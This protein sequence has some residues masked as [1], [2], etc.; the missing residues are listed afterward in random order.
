[1]TKNEKKV[2][3]STPETIKKKFKV[4]CAKHE[5]T[6]KYVLSEVMYRAVKENKLP[7]KLSKRRV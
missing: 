7:I 6:I 3:F 4:L 5:V 2:N 1:M